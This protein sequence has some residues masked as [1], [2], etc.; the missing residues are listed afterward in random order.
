M[1][2]RRG[3]GKLLTFFYVDNSVTFPSVVQIKCLL[4]LSKKFL[5]P[6]LKKQHSLLKTVPNEEMGCIRVAQELNIVFC[7]SF[8]RQG[9]P[10]DRLAMELDLQSLFGLHVHSCNHWLRT[11]LPALRLIE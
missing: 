6:Q 5:L 4:H 2:S 7:K 3:T 1:T 9:N 8:H 10:P 11:P